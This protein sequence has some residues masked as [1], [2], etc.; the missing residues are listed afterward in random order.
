MVWDQV[1]VTPEVLEWQ[2]R[3]S[4]ISDDP[5]VVEYIQND[6]RNSMAW[7]DW[8]KCSLTV[9]VAVVSHAISQAHLYIGDI[10]VVQCALN[11][12]YELTYNH[13]QR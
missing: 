3:G 12:D 6:Q 2:Y 10:N 11:N 4:G 9:L 5:F 7:A 8:K 1:L 13:T